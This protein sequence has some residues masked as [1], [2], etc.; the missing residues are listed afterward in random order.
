MVPH[1]RNPLFTG[2]EEVLDQIQKA[3]EK[4]RAAGI[5]QATG[6]TGLGGI[7][8]SQTALEYAYR[9]REEYAWVFWVGAESEETLGRD[10]AEMARRLELAVK[11]A[12]EAEVVREGV[13]AWLAGHGGYLLILDNADDPR[14]AAPYLPPSPRGHVLITSRARSL[15]ALRVVKPVELAVLPEGEAVDFLLARA[16]RAEDNEERPAAEELAKELGCL[17]L[18]LEQVGAYVA[19]QEIGFDE[20]LALYRRLRLRLLERGKPEW[21]ETERTVQSTWQASF[22]AVRLASP[23]AVDLLTV[24][25]FFAPEQIPYELL[26]LGAPELGEPLATALA[27]AAN[28]P[29]SLWELL[30][31]PV[32]Y[33]LVQRDPKTESYSLHVLV[34]EVVHATKRE[35]GDSVGMTAEERRAW[36]KRAVRAVNRAFPLVR[37]E[38]WARCERLLP[39]ALA[40]AGWIET[41]RLESAEAARL[42]TQVGSYLQERG[43]YAAAQALFQRAP[44]IYEAALGPEHRDTAASYGNLAGVYWAQGIFAKAEPLLKRAPAIHEQGQGP[45][46]R[47]RRPA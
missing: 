25:A 47:T 35:G 5:T 36:A 19:N 20:Y 26:I 46:H 30:T 8:K 42:L 39:H 23:A 2:R 44:A 21:G 22:T 11:E 3:L 7:G 32:T 34:Q 18:A 41:E 27:G 12:A 33:S 31:I 17:P 16:G 1:A 14:V 10:Y 28:D 45:G 15:R 37:L 43:Q 24:S 9:H 4:S 40:C 29:S 6:I 13:K 38:T